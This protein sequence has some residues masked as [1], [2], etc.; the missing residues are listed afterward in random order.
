MWS[1]GTLF[2]FFEELQMD[3]HM[4][5]VQTKSAP[6]VRILSCPLAVKSSPVSRGSCFI[7]YNHCHCPSLRNL[8][9][10]PPFSS[11]HSW[12]GKELWLYGARCV[13]QSEGLRIRS[14]PPP[15]ASFCKSSCLMWH[16]WAYIWEHYTWM[17][18]DLYR[19]ASTPDYK[20]KTGSV[21]IFVSVSNHSISLD[22][23]VRK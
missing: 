3:R 11:H 13:L 23:M 6:P 2:L 5:R 9:F 1:T 20:N 18:E 7:C 12:R 14:Q 10:C 15:W 4:D 19:E 16:W 22:R 8:F 21:I 17:A